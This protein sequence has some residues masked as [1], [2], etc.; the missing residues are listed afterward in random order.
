ML[1]TRTYRHDKWQRHVGDS[2]VLQSLYTCKDCIC[3]AREAFPPLGIMTE[4]LLNKR[5]Y[6]E[7][8]YQQ[9]ISLS[10]QVSTTRYNEVSPF[11]R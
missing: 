10:E 7:L 9:C 6:M 8:Y 4:F 11:E 5:T 3:V 1:S 2:S